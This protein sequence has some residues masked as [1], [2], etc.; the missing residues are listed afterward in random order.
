MPTRGAIPEETTANAARASARFLGD[1]SALR[2]SISREPSLSLSLLVRLFVRL[3]SE[4]LWR[5]SPF[6]LSRCMDFPG[7][8]VCEKA[9]AAA[10]SWRNARRGKAPRAPKETTFQAFLRNS[11]KKPRSQLPATPRSRGRN[12]RPPF[13]SVTNL[14]NF[15][16]QRR[17]DELMLFVSRI[18]RAAGKKFETPKTGPEASQER[19]CP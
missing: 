13:C 14:R 8:P 11:R 15:I 10:A 18:S 2:L 5:L 19:T 9:E 4:I 3:S 12:G 7:H 1:S 16:R 6:W 17:G